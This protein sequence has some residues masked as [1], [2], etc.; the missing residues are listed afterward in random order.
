MEDLYLPP[1]NEACEGYVFTGVFLSTR[2]AGLPLVPGGP[3]THTHPWADTP[4]PSGQTPPRQTPPGQTPPGRHTPPGQTPSPRQTHTH[5]GQT[6]PLTAGIR[7][8]PVHAGIHIPLPSACWDTVN[9]RAVRIP[10]ECIL[11]LNQDMICIIFKC[12]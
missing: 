9:K 5:P 7:P 1:A 2:G 11:V 12:L 4:H 6:P 10:L 8:H 3:A